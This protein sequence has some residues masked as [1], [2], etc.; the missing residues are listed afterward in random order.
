M[1]EK[2]K[3]KFILGIYK[4][5]EQNLNTIEVSKL[6]ELSNNLKTNFNRLNN[7]I[8]INSRSEM[9]LLINT[10]TSYPAFIWQEKLASIFNITSLLLGAIDHRYD[11]LMRN[12]DF[13]YQREN[14][15]Q[16][17]NLQIELE[18][19][20][21]YRN[22]VIEDFDE[23]VIEDENRDIINLIRRVYKTTPSYKAF[24]KIFNDMQNKHYQFELQGIN[25]QNYMLGYNNSLSFYIEELLGI[26]EDL[27]SVY[28][29]KRNKI[30]KDKNIVKKLVK[31]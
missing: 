23:F 7:A 21:N 5:K 29:K 24:D 25:I 8:L 13:Q 15:E 4:I 1:F 3:A 2:E 19:L 20:L 10:S 12:L 26:Y 11:D 28:Y 17:T 14:V 27:L 9:E 16:I 18:L 22:K 6:E 30:T 31:E